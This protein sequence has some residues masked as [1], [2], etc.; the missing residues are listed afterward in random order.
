MVHPYFIGINA[1]AACGLMLA[2]AFDFCMVGIV[3]SYM[4]WNRGNVGAGCAMK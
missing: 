3:L 1:F 4:P 2:G